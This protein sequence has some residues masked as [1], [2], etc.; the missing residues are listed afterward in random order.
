MPAAGFA[1]ALPV[2]V[3]D[4]GADEDGV[5]ELG[6]AVG[7]DAGDGV[8]EE[9]SCPGAGA[10]DGAAAPTGGCA[11]A[12]AGAELGG[13]ELAG[14]ELSVLAAGAVEES[15][16]SELCAAGGLPDFPFSH[17]SPWSLN[18]KY[19]NPTARASAKRMRKNLSSPLLLCS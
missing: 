14:A 12:G 9:E 7:V 17:A 19:P 18:R 13:A 8:V 6:V 15:A 10:P 3:A 16:A 11:A 1:G 2:E 4:D 5:E